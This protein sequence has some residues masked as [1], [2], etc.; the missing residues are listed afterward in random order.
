M[1]FIY[2]DAPVKWGPSNRGVL[3]KWGPCNRGVP[4]EWGLSNLGVPVK[5]G[6]SEILQGLLEAFSVGVRLRYGPALWLG[7]PRT[8]PW[9]VAERPRRAGQGFPASRLPP[10]NHP[11]A[12]C[13]ASLA[14]ALLRASGFVSAPSLVMTGAQSPAPTRTVRPIIASPSFRRSRRHRLDH[15]SDY[16]AKA[17]PRAE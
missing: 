5:R 6:P 16:P 7:A 3:V 15:G 2:P 10:F 17:S 11:L 12:R 13:P 4:G 8:H 1:G 14:R 9:W